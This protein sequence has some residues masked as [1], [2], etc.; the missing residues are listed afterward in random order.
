M[1][2]KSTKKLSEDE[3]KKLMFS[4]TSTDENEQ[5]ESEN[6]L[7][8][9]TISQLQSE[10]LKYQQPSLM[11]C[12]IADVHNKNKQATIKV[13]NGNQ[14][15]VNITS[16]CE[17]LEAGDT[18][19]CEQKNLTVIRKVESMKRFD[20]EQFVIIE[21][22]TVSFNDIGG[23]KDQIR[24]VKEVLELPLQRP[25]LFKQ[26][27]IEPPKG[28]LLHGPPGTGKTTT[29]VELLLQTL[30]QYENAKIL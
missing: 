27:G 12:E 16:G 14:F 30:D 23:L 8:R 2:A 28:V 10:L 21:K 1:S 19:L 6:K 26:V 29:V 15:Y 17:K 4:Y 20:I 18:V 11:I 7:L 13:P 5:L 24:E 25:E 22:P 9:E 3:I